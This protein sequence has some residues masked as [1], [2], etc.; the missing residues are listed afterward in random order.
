[1]PSS[2]SALPP[3]PVGASTI[4]RGSITC[5]TGR[6]TEAIG[7]RRSLYRLPVPAARAIDRVMRLDSV[8]CYPEL[9]WLATERE[10]AEFF[11]AT[12]PSLASGKVPHTT[13]GAGAKRRVRRFRVPSSC[14][15]PGRVGVRLRA[16]ARPDVVPARAHF[17]GSKACRLISH[18]GSTDAAHCACRG[19]EDPGVVRDAGTTVAWAT[20]HRNASRWPRA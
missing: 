15:D 16:V 11:T 12:V 7:E 1:M 3:H 6:C 18:G 9:R 19:T 20:V 4:A 13:S 5:S 10:K 17:D 8:L 14:S 2:S